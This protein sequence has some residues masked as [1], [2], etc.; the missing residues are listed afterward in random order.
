MRLKQSALASMAAGSLLLLAACGGSG[1]GPGSGTDGPGNEDITSGGDTGSGT[2]PDREGPVT[3]EGA[4]EGGTVTV[5]SGDGVNSLDPSEA[6]YTNTI[7]ILNGLVTRSLTQ[8]SYDPET[9]Q[10]VLVPDLATDLGTPN[11]DF[12]EWQFTI[13]DGVRWQNGDEVTAEDVAYG[14]KRSFDRQAFPEGPAFSNDYFLDGDTYRGPYKSGEE[15]AGIEV[16]GSTITLKMSKPFPDM[17]YWGTFPAMG[18][19]PQDEAI[20]DPAEYA[21]NPWSNGPYMFEEYTPEQSLTLVQN[22]EWDPATDPARTQ[23]PDEYVFDFATESAQIDQ[24]LLQ[25]SGEAQTTLSYDDILAENYPSFLQD[26]S[27]RMVTTGTPCTFYW[28]P[29]YRKV[30]D[31][32]VRRALAFAYPYE[33]ALQSAGLIEGVNRIFGTNLMPPGIPGREEYQTMEEQGFTTAG[34]DPEKA[35]EL[36]AEAG[37]EGYEIRFLFANDDPLSV[38]TK[39]TIAAALEEAGF[40]AT[41]VASTVAD[42]STD[43]ANPDFDINVRSAGWCSDWPAGSSWFPP[44]TESTNLE[45]EGL[46]SNYAVFSEDD[47]DT[48]I[49][50]ILAAPLE[51][52]P[53]LWNE[54][55][56][57]ISDTYFPMFV[58]S[59]SGT[60]W[61][62]GSGLQGVQPDGTSGLPDWKN[63]SVA[64]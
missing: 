11:E 22:P 64:Q 40:T 60:S 24:L 15:Y 17:P 58:T 45:E 55:D 47:V 12:T 36:L 3:I 46:G 13:R 50:D 48:R 57:Y 18:A 56:K 7:S 6:Y 44:L 43:R 38:E 63:I 9:G 32:N 39:N 21:R 41:P 61:A 25:D 8:Y 62:Y 16:D 23:Y 34:T 30:T 53:G 31:V 26:A 29:D 54:L 5:L 35:R 20:N 33:E 27:D 59:Y 2:D 10:A 51:D 1:D 4:Q 28:A 37:E 42:I 19:I 49:A 52:Q 14:I